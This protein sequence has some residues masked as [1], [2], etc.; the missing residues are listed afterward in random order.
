LF[1]FRTPE[2]NDELRFHCIES[3]R[4]EIFSAD[5]AVY[6]KGKEKPALQAPIIHK[7][8]N[9]P[10]SLVGFMSFINVVKFIEVIFCWVGPLSPG[11]GASSGCRWR[12]W[13]PDMEGSCK[14]IE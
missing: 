10:L 13:P 7:N 12:R 8:M 11:H 1:F 6:Q 3:G 2:E 4:S 14:Y 5:F 9:K